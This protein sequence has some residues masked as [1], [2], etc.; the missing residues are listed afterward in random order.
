M[1]QQIEIKE[2]G[3]GRHPIL[4]KFEEGVSFWR[5]VLNSWWSTNRAGKI[6]AKDVLLIQ[7][8]INQKIKNIKN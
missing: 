7:E 1:R 5:N 2:K 3:A 6:K 8:H 4:C